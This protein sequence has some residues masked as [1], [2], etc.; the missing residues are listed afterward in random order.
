[1]TDGPAP[2]SAKALVTRRLVSIE[3]DE[4][5]FRRHITKSDTYRHRRSHPPLGVS[6]ISL[7]GK[8]NETE[9]TICVL[10]GRNALCRDRNNRFLATLLIPMLVPGRVGVS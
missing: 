3:N 6:V 9:A 4:S 1:M 5:P 10:A 8:V 7:E 2:V